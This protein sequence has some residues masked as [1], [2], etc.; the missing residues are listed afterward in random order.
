MPPFR[1]SM[2]DV[3]TVHLH[4]QV[5]KITRAGTTTTLATNIFGPLAFD[6][7]GTLYLGQVGVIVTIAPNG[8]VTLLV[9][10]TTL[11]SPAALAFGI[12]SHCNLYAVPGNAVLQIVP[13]PS[14][15]LSAVLPGSRPVQVATPAT[16]VQ[17]LCPGAR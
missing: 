14:S 2:V 16:I 8:T 13:V 17:L 7:G 6:R 11:S 12:R 5:V 9:S 3:S 15:L 10:S 4:A 1:G